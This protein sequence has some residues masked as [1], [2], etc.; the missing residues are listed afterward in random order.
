MD[1]PAD[2]LAMRFGQVR[3]LQ[4]PPS[5]ADQSYADAVYDSEALAENPL[6]ALPQQRGLLLVRL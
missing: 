3:E 1:I 2:A 4:P 6:P 5:T